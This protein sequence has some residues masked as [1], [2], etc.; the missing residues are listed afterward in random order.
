MRVNVDEGFRMLT[1][2]NFGSSLMLK[3]I[4]WKSNLINFK[5]REFILINLNREGC[6]R[7]MR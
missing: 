6:M 7:K 4:V 3:R 2:R 1:P 5:A